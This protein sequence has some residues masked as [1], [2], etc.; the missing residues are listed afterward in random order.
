MLP[1]QACCW[2][3]EGKRNPLMHPNW[4]LGFPC[5]WSAIVS[6]CLDEM[7]GSPASLGQTAEPPELEIPLC[8]F[9]IARTGLWGSCGGSC[10]PSFTTPLRQFQSTWPSAILLSQHRWVMGIGPARSFGR[11]MLDHLFTRSLG[12]CHSQWLKQRWLDHNWLNHHWLMLLLIT[13]PASLPHPHEDR[14]MASITV[15]NVTTWGPTSS[16]VALGP[17]S[18][19]VA[20]ATL[21][22]WMAGPCHG[23]VVQSLPAGKQ[24]FEI[25]KYTPIVFRL[26][27]SFRMPF[28][29]K[30]C[31]YDVNTFF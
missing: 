17:R 28:F 9:H 31:F 15:L 20:L 3:S 26:L 4:H 10:I 8:S 12:F 18:P 6:I 24:N 14:T 27:K 13:G 19:E 29:G 25:H 7:I 21:D 30:Y 16:A 5:K 23:D 11:S 1:R 22:A 2:A